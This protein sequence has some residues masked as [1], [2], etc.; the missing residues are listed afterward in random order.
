MYIFL[1]SKVKVR[2]KGILLIVKIFLYF[3]DCNMNKPQQRS[4]SSI[5]KNILKQTVQERGIQK[6]AISSKSTSSGNKL[7]ID[8]TTEEE[9][10]ETNFSF[11]F[12]ARFVLYFA[13]LIAS[14]ETFRVTND[15]K[16]WFKNR[17]LH[18]LIK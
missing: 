11:D 18:W 4:A 3:S 17:L 7:M 8:L 16:N 15:N 14:E 13:L 1:I 2:V 6:K 5:E 10:K 9:P 12:G